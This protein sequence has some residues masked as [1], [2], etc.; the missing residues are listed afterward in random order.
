[1]ANT[2]VFVAKNLAVMA[3]A[4]GFTLWQ[5]KTSNTT[6]E[7]SSPGYFNEAKSYLAEKDMIIL[8]AADKTSQVI[9]AKAE[10]G[11]V[12]ISPLVSVGGSAI[13][14]ANAIADVAL[15]D[16]GTAYE[17]AAL[18]TSLNELKAK[19]NAVLAALR[20]TGVV[21]NS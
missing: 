19:L 8:Q 5:Y 9:V 17:Q 4:N 20:T 7:A 3:Y 11:S 16:Q 15:T 1:M 18:N 13:T 14:P 12:A 10:D 6:A 2:P 21:K